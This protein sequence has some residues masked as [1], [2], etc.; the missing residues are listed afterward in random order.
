M[1]A[2]LSRLS[3]AARVLAGRMVP[4][5][6]ATDSNQAERLRLLQLV[7]DSLGVGIIRMT[8]AGPVAEN[9]VM[10]DF[11][12]H[13]GGLAPFLGGCGDLKLNDG[14]GSLRVFEVRAIEPG[15]TMVSDVTERRGVEEALQSVALFPAQN[16]HPVLR[17][18]ADGTVR[19]ANAASEELL[20]E[21][22]CGINRQ[23]PPAWRRAVAEALSSGKRLQ[24]EV[25]V[26]DKV[27]S[28][29]MVPLAGPDYVNIYA[30]DVTARVAAERLLFSLND[31]LERRV[32][33]RTRDLMEAKEQAEIASRSKS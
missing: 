21:W 27:L 8:A 17:I 33:E 31:S 13:C 25:A 14:Y 24:D 28:L 3:C 11:A 2:V 5:R 20:A 19:H 4:E 6:L 10:A 30:A 32:A 29:T 16:P 22:G 23:I 15:Q 9:A 26:G 1:R 7:T 18:A 12:A